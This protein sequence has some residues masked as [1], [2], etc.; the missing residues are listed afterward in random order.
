MRWAEDPRSS[1]NALRHRS[2]QPFWNTSLGTTCPACLEL[3]QV[4]LR[5]AL[6]RAPMSQRSK[7]D[8]SARSDRHPAHTPIAP[9][10]P[11]KRLGAKQVCT[12]SGSLL[13]PRARTPAGPL[14]TGRNI[15]PS[16][17]ERLPRKRRCGRHRVLRFTHGCACWLALLAWGGAHPTRK[18]RALCDSRPHRLLTFSDIS[19]VSIGL[20]QC[21]RIRYAIMSPSE[22]MPSAGAGANATA[23]RAAIREPCA[24]LHSLATSLRQQLRG[25][26]LSL[27]RSAR[28]RALFRFTCSRVGAF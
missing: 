26:F 18:L 13:C 14:N 11:S 2:E 19:A 9:S 28:T 23:H 3:S 27:G 16:P 22:D 6:P 24:P 20:E 5:S 1:P 12:L 7:G 10:P 25:I 21:F 17:K 4:A 15:A 8:E